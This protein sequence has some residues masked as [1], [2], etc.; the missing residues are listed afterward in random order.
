MSAE[1]PRVAGSEE[2]RDLRLGIIRAAAANLGYDLTE[3]G[4]DAIPTTN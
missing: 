2:L 3:R 4:P 1:K